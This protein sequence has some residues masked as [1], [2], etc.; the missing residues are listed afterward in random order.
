MRLAHEKRNGGVPERVNGERPPVDPSPSAS[1]T[2][3]R[4]APTPTPSNDHH[5]DFDVPD[6]RLPEAGPRK[7]SECVIG[8]RTF[9]VVLVPQGETPVLSDRQRQVTRLVGK[10]LGNKGIA[11]RLGI[12][13]RTVANHLKEAFQKVG[14]TSRAELARWAGFGL[15]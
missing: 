11:N 9:S 3:A 6:H 14:V 10:G 15:L 12:S 1:S 7:V 13:E 5:V 4:E 8:E 2:S